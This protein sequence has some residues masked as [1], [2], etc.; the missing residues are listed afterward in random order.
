MICPMARISVV[1]PVYN[2]ERYLRDCLDSV[3]NQTMSDWEAICINDGSTD[4][5]GNILTE[6]AARLFLTEVTSTM[7]AVSTTTAKSTQTAN[8]ECALLHARPIQ[9]ATVTTL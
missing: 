7:H 2:V 6:Y 1:I 9:T 4:G 5:S 8:T 3:L